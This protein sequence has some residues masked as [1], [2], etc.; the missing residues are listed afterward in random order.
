VVISIPE[1]APPPLLAGELNCDR[2][3]PAKAAGAPAN[4]APAPSA[5][6]SAPTSLRDEGIDVGAVIAELDSRYHAP[7]AAI[8]ERMLRQYAGTIPDKQLIEEIGLALAI[9]HAR[10]VNGQLE[11]SVGGRVKVPTPCGDF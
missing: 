7:R 2:R 5:T 8:I 6:A 9:H 1:C 3:G 10:I 11:V 4:I